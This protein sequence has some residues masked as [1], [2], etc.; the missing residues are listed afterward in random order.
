LE[1]Y[2]DV[3]VS[4]ADNLQGQQRAIWAEGEVL[5]MPRHP[6]AAKPAAQAVFVQQTVAMA[7]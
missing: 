1:G 5:R 4:A 2:I 3:Q 7:F 6:A